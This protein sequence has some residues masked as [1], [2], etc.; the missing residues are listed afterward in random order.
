MTGALRTV[1]T[2]VSAEATP[3]SSVIPP[4]P[5]PLASASLASAPLAPARDLDDRDRSLG[6]LAA[7]V[8]RFVPAAGGFV[9]G[10]TSVREAD[11]PAGTAVTLARMLALHLNDEVLIVEADLRRPSRFES[12]LGVPSRPGLVDLLA[13]PKSARSPSGHRAAPGVL[14]VGS[15]C[16]GE[17]RRFLSG[18]SLSRV[19]VGLRAQAAVTIIVSP[20][21]DEAGDGD[22]VA[23][24]C[25]RLIVVVE[26]D[27]TPRAALGAA[28]ERAGRERFL[29]AVVITPKRPRRPWESRRG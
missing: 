20:P 13:Y 28:I 23:A 9:L 4:A 6:R 22:V 1:P 21:L 3:N 12:L 19:I 10:V 29:G 18:T 24:S 25:D 7:E 27:S 5:T 14:A 11:D 26:Q 2:S 8:L 16:E 17:E 15:G